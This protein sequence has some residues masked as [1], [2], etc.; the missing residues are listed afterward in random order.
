MCGTAQDGQWRLQNAL[1][2]PH[3]VPFQS[4][5]FLSRPL[6]T[7]AGQNSLQ[8]TVGIGHISGHHEVDHAV[9]SGRFPHNGFHLR[10]VKKAFWE[11][12]ARVAAV[13]LILSSPPAGSYPLPYIT[14]IDKNPVIG[15]PFLRRWEGEG[16]PVTTYARPASVPLESLSG[17]PA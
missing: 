17:A 1:S 12:H 13:A 2:D 8:D 6:K 9:R 4:T 16:T 5:G 10:T 14:P 3:T 11:G 7:A 15:T